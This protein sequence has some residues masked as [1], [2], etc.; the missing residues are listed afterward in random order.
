MDQ[1]VNRI[2]LK[3]EANCLK[4]IKSKI[5]W[6]KVRKSLRQLR[7]ILLK[8]IEVFIIDML[9]KILTNLDWGTNVGQVKRLRLVANH[10]IKELSSILVA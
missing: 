1:V 7:D 5:N 10:L 2:S 6:K 3:L 8:T 4:W 9:T